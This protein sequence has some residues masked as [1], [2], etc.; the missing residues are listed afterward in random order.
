[1]AFPESE[2]QAISIRNKFCCSAS[3]L[4]KNFTDTFRMQEFTVKMDFTDP[5]LSSNYGLYIDC[6]S[7]LSTAIFG[8]VVPLLDL[9]SGYGI[10]DTGL[11]NLLD[12][13]ITK[14]LIKIDAISRIDEFGSLI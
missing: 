8:F 7:V 5:V 13:S 11:L 6:M 1:M 2:N 10:I 4:V 14:L 9:D 3:T 12:I